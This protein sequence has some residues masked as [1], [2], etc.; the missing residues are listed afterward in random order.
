MSLR[1]QFSLRLL[2]AL[3]ALTAVGMTFRIRTHLAVETTD[4][5]QLVY[6]YHLNEEGKKIPHGS[7][8]RRRFDNGFNYY[9]E[10][11]YYREGRHL[12]IDC[13]IQAHSPQLLGRRVL[14]RAKRCICYCGGSGPTP[15]V[16]PYKPTAEEEAQV[17][18]AVELERLRMEQFGQPVKIR[19]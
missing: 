13:S 2:L 7:Y 16:N 18:V 12:L 3:V 10:V 5:Q 15:V 6:H 1:P 19:Y 8:I 14:G 17:H 4:E 11:T 9:T